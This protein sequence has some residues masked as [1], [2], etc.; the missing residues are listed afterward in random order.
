MIGSG[1]SGGLTNTNSNLIISD[2]NAGLT[3]LQNNGGPT[4]TIALA[5]TS[6][7]IGAGSTAISGVAVPTTD[8]RG[9]IRTSSTIDAGAY[10]SG[11][12]IPSGIVPSTTTTTTSTTSGT[13]AATPPPVVL[14]TTVPTP[15]TPVTP[16][17]TPVVTKAS[18]V[19]TKLAS[20]K[21]HPGAGSAH[22]FHKAAVT[23]ANKH[24]AAAKS[25]PAAHAK[26]N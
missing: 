19:K 24:V 6:P 11:A 14:T 3:G 1:G 22:K 8:Q 2:A 26:K 20:K 17:V 16:V 9:G 5:T 23:K 12:T 15:V 21:S 13:K 18:K 25:H 10:Q 4:A 7:A